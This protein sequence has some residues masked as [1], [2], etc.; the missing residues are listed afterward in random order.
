[1]K[2]HTSKRALPP[3]AIVVSRYNASVTD[4]LLAG[5]A[6]AYQRAGGRL[7]NLHIAEAPGAFELVP[8]CAAAARQGGFAGVVALGCIIRGETRHDEVLGDAVTSGLANLALITG[9]PIGLGV[10]TV[11]TPAQAAARAGGKL[12]N[13]GEEA[14]LA[15]IASIGEIALLSDA[16]ELKLAAAAG[17]TSRRLMASGLGVLPDKARAGAKRGNAGGRR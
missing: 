4:R 2:Q 8:I 1:M 9:V 7:G 3:V 16:R 17:L 12:G 5:A 10:L 14:M 6:L 15:V 13:K 11:D